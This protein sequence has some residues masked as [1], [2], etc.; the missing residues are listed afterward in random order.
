MEQK[1][2]YEIAIEEMKYLIDEQSKTVDLAKAT[3]R[4]ILSAASLIVALVAVLPILGSPINASNSRL[5][6][7]LIIAAGVLFITLI[8]LCVLVLA[9]RR[10]AGP[11]LAD[12]NEIWK[13]LVNQESELDILKMRLSSYLNVLRLNKSAVKQKTQ[14]ANIAAALLPAIVAILLFAALIR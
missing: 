11:F 6:C 1:L 8:I 4:Q 12:W 3:A 14:F 13:T 10:F 2:G 9:M 5:Y 7:C